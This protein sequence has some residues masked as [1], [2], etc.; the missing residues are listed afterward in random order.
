MKSTKLIMLASA[1]LM[2]AIILP[3]TAMA[4]TEAPPVLSARDL[5]PAELLAG[6]DFKVDDVVPTDGFYGIFTVRGTYGSIQ[7][8]GGPEQH[9]QRV[10]R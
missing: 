6:P 2:L 3:T 5:A 4:Q 7:A 10:H 9:V 8:R 1:S